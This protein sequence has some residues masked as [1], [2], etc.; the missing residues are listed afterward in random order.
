MD[1]VRNQAVKPE[2][3]KQKARVPGHVY[4]ITEQDAQAYPFVVI[5]TLSLFDHDAQILIDSG[6]THSFI[7]CCYMRHVNS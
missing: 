4:A 6:F 3:P 7:T 2:Q 5:G 1:K